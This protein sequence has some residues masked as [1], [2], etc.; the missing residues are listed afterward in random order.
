M[1]PPGAGKTAFCF[2]WV[3]QN[4]MNDYEPTMEDSLEN[5]V[6]VDGVDVHVELTDTA[7]QDD[8]TPQCTIWAE[9]SDGIILMYD[10]TNETS[11][12]TV[13]K[14]YKSPDY[15]NKNIIIVGSKCDLEGRVK[16][17][18]VENEISHR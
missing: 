13:Q 15:D 8:F 1:G 11:W 12:K 4:F 18:T 3:N 14:M 9:N 6:K 17:K 10:V 5:K 16:K 7:G 2:R